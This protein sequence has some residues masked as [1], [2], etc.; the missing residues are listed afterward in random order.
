MSQS[1][2]HIWDTFPFP[3]WKLHYTSK[4]WQCCET[5]E[6]TKH[7]TTQHNTVLPTQHNTTQRNTTQCCDRSTQSCETTIEE[8]DLSFRGFH[9]WRHLTVHLH[10][11]EL[12]WDTFYHRYVHLNHALRYIGIHL[13]YIELHLHHRERC[14]C[15]TLS[16]IL[17]QRCTFELHWDTLSYICTGQ[18]P[19]PGRGPVSTSTKDNAKRWNNDRFMTFPPLRPLSVGWPQR[20]RQR[21]RQWQ[22][23]I[24]F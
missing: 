6:N 13:N 20:Q 24:Q 16:Y 14:D 21:Q 8:L 7:K 18:P 1:K 5:C 4:C 17:P 9:V 22:W 3:R 10:Y 19:G 2:I 23:Q 12:H 11:R 15:T